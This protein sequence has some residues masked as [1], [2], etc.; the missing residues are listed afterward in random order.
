VVT[1]RN[2][3]RQGALLEGIQGKLTLGEIIAVTYK[4][5]KGRFRVTWVG[6]ADTDTA[7]QIGVQSVDPAKCIWDATTLPPTAAD[8]YSPPLAKE[9]RQHRRVQCKLGAELHTEGA[10]ALVRGEVTNLSIGGCFLEMSTLP[11]DKSR[12]KLIV[13]VNDSKLVVKGI[14]VSRRPGFGISIRFTEVTEDVREQLGRFVQ[15]HLAF[16]GR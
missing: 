7:G 14:V 15:S 5:N 16:R 10:E 4:T 13:W 2:I 11:E 3:S 8:T 1:T 12:L 6:D 9:R